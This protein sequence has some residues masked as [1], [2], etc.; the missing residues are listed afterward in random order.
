M[1]ASCTCWPFARGIT[2][3]AAAA[4]AREGVKGVAWVARAKAEVEVAAARVGAGGAAVR[5]AA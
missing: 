2:L 4:V 5:V 1:L 3:A